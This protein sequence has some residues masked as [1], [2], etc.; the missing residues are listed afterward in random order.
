MLGDCFEV[1]AKNVMDNKHLYLVHAEVSGQ[2]DLEGVRFAHAWCEVGD[3]V[4]DF[5]NGRNIVMRK[6]Q[7]YKLGKVKKVKKKY[8][9]YN[10][11]EA[12]ENLISSRHY[13]PWDLNTKR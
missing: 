3:I 6:E 1:A 5:S 4:M 13:G 11:T 8:A 2:G 7:Y 9:R 10:F 12:M